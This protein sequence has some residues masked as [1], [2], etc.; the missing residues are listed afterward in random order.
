[1]SDHGTDPVVPRRQKQTHLTEEVKARC[2]EALQAGSFVKDAVEYAGIR[3]E[4]RYYAWVERGEAYDAHLD[5][6]GEIIEGEDL[7]RQF[8]IEVTRARAE[9]RVQA[10][11]S[12]RKAWHDGDWRAAEKFLAAGDR[13]SWERVQKVE[14][15]GPNGGPLEVDITAT[16]VRLAE[17]IR[18]R[19]EAV[20]IVDAE[21]IAVDAVVTHAIG[22]A[23]DDDDYEEYVVPP[24]VYDLYD[25]GSDA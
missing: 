9:A 8:A 15:G 21:V 7:Y 14:L 10:A 3:T 12:I 25:F 19:R 17:S 2:V 18:V 1:M 5:D 23:A 22:A 11:L 20:E 24:S 16:E 4:R 13:G 6:G